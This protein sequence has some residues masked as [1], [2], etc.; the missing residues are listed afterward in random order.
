MKLITGALLLAVAF[1][2]TTSPASAATFKNCAAVNEVYPGG[3]AKSKSSKNVGGET[4]LKPTVNSKVYNSVYKK[5]D[6]DKDGI[7]CEK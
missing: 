6:R 7:A 4:K 1:T 2:S 5:L 3:V